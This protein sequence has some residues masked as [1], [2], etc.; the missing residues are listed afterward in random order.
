[1]NRRQFI[2]L[3]TAS[4]VTLAGCVVLNLPGPQLLP[5]DSIPSAEHDATIQRMRPPKRQRPVVAVLADHHGSETTDFIVPWSVLTRSGMCE[6]KTVGTRKGV[7][8]LM[9]AL[10]IGVELSTEEFD[11]LYPDGADYVIVPAFHDPKNS[12]ALAWIRDQSQRGATMIG[13]CAGALPLAYAG[14]LEGKNATTHWFD[15]SNLTRISP[16]TRIVLDRRYVADNGVV[17][18]TG[19]SASLPLA[20]ALVE[21]IAGR[22]KARD[23]AASLHVAHFDARHISENYK[24]RMQHV[25]QIALNKGAIWRQE[26][27]AGAIIPNT[28]ELGLALEADAWSRTYRSQYLTYC[29][30]PSVMSAHGLEIFRDIAPDRASA[31][32]AAPHTAHFGERRL[33]EVLGQ[34]AERYGKRTAGLVALQLEYPWS[35]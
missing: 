22:E 24:L 10:R 33:N 13:I 1:M 2:F 6:V 12:A 27:I 30:V 19:V 17:T 35:D 34:I 16:S 15:R 9:P 32:S 3:A 14:V 28:D 11:Q 25:L 18:S 4:T 29:E 31:M 5:A 20:L 23:L 21:A 7:V 26:K 8:Q